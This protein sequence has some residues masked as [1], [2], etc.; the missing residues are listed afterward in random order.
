MRPDGFGRGGGGV[1]HERNKSTKM[2]IKARIF[3]W[4]WIF[5]SHAGLEWA[6]GPGGR[7]A[8]DRATVRLI[9]V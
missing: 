7:V 9:L 2:L 1:R 4:I 8:V 3:S 6:C 5:L